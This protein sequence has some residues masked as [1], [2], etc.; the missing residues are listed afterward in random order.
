MR[1]IIWILFAL[2]SFGATLW[3]A[4]DLP[5][6]EIMDIRLGVNEPDPNLTVLVRNRGE[7]YV[8]DL[9]FSLSQSGTPAIVRRVDIDRN[10]EARVVLTTVSR[11]TLNASRCGILYGVRVDPANLIR[12][13]NEGNN[14]FTKTVLKWATPD[15]CV[16][17]PAQF[18]REAFKVNISRQLGATINYF[19]QDDQVILDKLTGRHHF[20]AILFVKIKNCGNLPITAGEID[21]TIS[22]ACSAEYRSGFSIAP[23]QTA[24]LVIPLTYYLRSLRSL[25]NRS[26]LGISVMNVPGESGVPLLN[27]NYLDFTVQ[28]NFTPE[29]LARQAAM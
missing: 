28:F 9:A 3:G 7:R 15:A 11:A 18:G 21:F 4:P 17:L 8:G 14:A 26:R 2:A 22:Q 19:V 5:D 25:R 29:M 16:M 6:F 23:G 10:V 1:A 13:A 12:E 20:N 24:E 27:N